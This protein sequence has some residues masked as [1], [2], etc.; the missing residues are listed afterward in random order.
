M[1][2]VQL[3]SS[4]SWRNLWRNYR[5]TFIT[6][7]S[8]GV[9]VWAMIVLAALMQAWA[10]STFNTSINTLMGH[11]QIHAEHYLDDPSIDYRFDPAT[12]KQLELL[13]APQIKAWS[14]RI[15]VPAIVQSERE[16]APL[17][18]V[19]ILPDAETGLSFI[20]DSIVSGV[21]LKPQKSSDILL[22]KK[23]AKRLRT[24][25]GKRIVIL[26]QHADGSISERGFRIVG[27][28][29]VDQEETETQFAFVNLHSAQTMLGAGQQISEISFIVENTDELDSILLKFSQLNEADNSP[30]DIKRWSELEPF[31]LAILDMTSSTIALLTVIMFILISFG[32]INTLLMAVYERTREFGLLQALGMKPTYILY[33]ILI[34]S[35]FLMGIGVS[36]GFVVSL[37]TIQYFSDG[38]NLGI[39]AEGATMFGAGKIMYP[40]INWLQSI[41]IAT[42]VWLMG[43]VVSLYPAWRASREV[44]VETINK[45]Y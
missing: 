22:G 24:E 3:L 37:L 38:L 28:Y 30:L 7:S 12:S 16:S 45:A 25:V 29:A 35:V 26:S 36:V 21:Y 2:R 19:G 23:L 15:R 40:E 11:A 44:P 6:F 9:G 18:L 43:V 33:M 10:M 8:I 13:N 20:P 41:L 34:E 14:Q 31:T 1:E 42:I 27:I 4:L 5:R 32:L 39:L 17:T